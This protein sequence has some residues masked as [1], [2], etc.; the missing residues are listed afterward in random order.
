[1]TPHV[2]S[3]SPVLSTPYLATAAMDQ[4]LGLHAASLRQPAL[5][6]GSSSDLVNTTLWCGF[7]SDCLPR[8][9]SP[10]TMVKK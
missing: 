3:L 2:I 6:L 5:P 7:R 9:R 1:M 8:V 10:A 4:S